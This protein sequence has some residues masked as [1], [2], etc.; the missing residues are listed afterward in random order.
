MVIPIDPDVSEVTKV[1]YDRLVANKESY[2]LIAESEAVV[3]LPEPPPPIQNKKTRN[4]KTRIELN[5]QHV[6]GA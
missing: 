3:Q 5:E 1:T 2:E 6:L 4:H